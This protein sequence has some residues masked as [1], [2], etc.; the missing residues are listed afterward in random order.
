MAGT[1]IIR[2]NRWPTLAKHGDID[3]LLKQ[4]DGTPMPEEVLVLQQI[5]YGCLDDQG[6]IKVKEVPAPTPTDP[7]AKKVVAWVCDPGDVGTV[8]PDKG[9]GGGLG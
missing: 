3:T 4:A 2:G 7:K 9:P 5:Q 6:A 1:I 8:G